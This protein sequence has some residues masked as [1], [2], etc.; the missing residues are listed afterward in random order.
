[1]EGSE[2]SIHHASYWQK[3]LITHQIKWDSE[4]GSASP[5]RKYGLFKPHAC[6]V[7]SV[8]CWC[9][10]LRQ[11]FLCRINFNV[12][13]E[14]IRLILSREEINILLEVCRM[15]GEICRWHT[16]MRC[17]DPDGPGQSSG[18]RWDKRKERLLVL[19]TGFPLFWQIYSITQS[20]ISVFTFCQAHS[21]WDLQSFFSLPFTAL[22]PNFVTFLWVSKSEIVYL[23]GWMKD[24]FLFQGLQRKHCGLWNN[25][26]C[27]QTCI[28]FIR[29]KCSY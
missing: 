10:M 9:W 1:M 20:I 8:A 26:A 11:K 5:P 27:S 14:A 25:V 13:R 29:Q 17:F 2:I 22:F 19:A 18:D 28:L 3:C 6:L 7:K 16:C 23:C 21:V 4:P 12:T 15:C 24:N